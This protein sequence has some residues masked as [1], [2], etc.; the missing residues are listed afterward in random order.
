MSNVTLWKSAFLASDKTLGIDSWESRL[1]IVSPDVH[2]TIDTMRSQ[3]MQTDLTGVGINGGL[4]R[5]T[6]FEINEVMP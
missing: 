5:D 4:T 2:E 1:N 3:L 6:K